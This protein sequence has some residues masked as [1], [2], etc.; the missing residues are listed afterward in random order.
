MSG[1][2][3]PQWRYLSE[4][5]PVRF[6]GCGSRLLIVRV[7]R[8]LFDDVWATDMAMASSSQGR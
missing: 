8:R 4:T 2:R 6:A 5:Y 1:R 7:G 3:G